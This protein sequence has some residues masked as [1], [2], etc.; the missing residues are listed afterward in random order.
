MSTPWPWITKEA[1]AAPRSAPSPMVTRVAISTKTL[2]LFSSASTLRNQVTV[3]FRVCCNAALTRVDSA[4]VCT[5]CRTAPA[6]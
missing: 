2:E 6:N 4:E 1:V 5:D 3:V